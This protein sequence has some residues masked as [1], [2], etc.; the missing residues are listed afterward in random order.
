MCTIGIVYRKS[1][2]II[3]EQCD[4]NKRTLFYK[5]KIKSNKDISYMSFERQD[6]EGT[7]CGINNYGV[8]FVSADCY[9]KDNESSSLSNNGKEF[10]AYEN[11][12]SNYKTAREA[13]EFIK[14][15]Y[16]TSLNKGILIISDKKESYYIEGYNGEVIVVLLTPEF[17]PK[18]LVSTNHFRF[19][20]EEVSFKEN[21]STYLRLTRAEEMLLKDCSLNGVKNLLK[22]Q[23][24]GKSVMSICRESDICP[25]GEKVYTTQ[26]TAI[27]LVNNNCNDISTYY[28]INGNPKENKMIFKDRIFN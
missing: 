8:G 15:F 5:P 6:I 24:Y 18:H 16:S 21:H 28:Q 2:M 4:L 14:G 25:S 1:A 19:I 12:I 27:F 10:K 17:H 23:Y 26:A 9:V 13:V 7:W 20:H 11:I 3:F 22:D